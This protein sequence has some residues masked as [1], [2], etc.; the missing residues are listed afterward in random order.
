MIPVWIINLADS[1]VDRSYLKQLYE[2][3]PAHKK[4]YWFVTDIEAEAVTDERSC[5][6]L[7]NELI[8]KGRNCYDFF[9]DKGFT[10]NNLQVCIIGTATEQVTRTTFHLIPSMLREFMSSIQSEYVHRGIEITGLLYVPHNMNHAPERERAECALFIEEMNT[11]V[12]KLDVDTYSRIVV[13]QNIQRPDNGARFYSELNE[14]QQTAYIFQLLLHIYYQDEKQTKIFDSRGLD[15][16]GYYSLGAASIYYDSREHKEQKALALLARLTEM[17]KDPSYVFEDDTENMVTSRFPKAS[18][19]AE[20][21]LERLKENCQGLNVDLKTLEAQPNPHPIN[22]FYKA[23]LYVSYYMDYLKFMPA[24]ALEF[25]RLYSYML[26]KKLFGQIKENKLRLKE[27]FDTILKQYN[28]I[29]AEEDYKYPTFPQLKAALEELKKRFGKEKEQVERVLVREEQAVFEIPE[30]LSVYFN[31]FKS[32]DTE[33]SLKD[34]AEKMKEKLKWEP[35]VMSTLNRSFLLGTVMVFVLLPLLSHLSPF[36]INL[37]DVDKYSYLWIGVIFLLPFAYQLF[38]RLHRHFLSICNSKRMMLAKSLVEVRQKTSAMLCREAADFYAMMIKACDDE[39]KKYQAIEDNL[40]V[41]R[42]RE[43]NAE[44]PHTFF[45]QPL[46]DGSFGGKKMLLKDDVMGD[47]IVLNGMTMSLSKFRDNDYFN[48][49]NGIFKNPDTYLFSVTGEDEAAIEQKITLTLEK[50]R[51]LLYEKL[52]IDDEQCL[53]K[54]INE[55][56]QKDDKAVELIPLFRMAGVNGVITDSASERGYVIRSYNKLLHLPKEASDAIYFENDKDA[57]PF[58]FVTTWSRPYPNKLSAKAICDTQASLSKE[59]LPF[60][61]MLTCL[62]AQYKK[63]D[64]NYCVAGIKTP[65]T[66]DELRQLESN[67]N[68][69]KP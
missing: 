36:I 10:I 17:V 57:K 8:S 25:V 56:Q 24:R 14:E 47:D 49:L 32:E 53:T 62:Y 33:T 21:T 11:I 39:I 7:L 30:Y 51:S 31:K 29:F 4:P 48:L 46:I 23:G 45:N 18:I 43:S 38:V 13:C 26:T 35:T 66:T 61:T 19:A 40:S 58:V 42:Q 27:H 34:I 68:K 20:T 59:P 55:I 1:D 22:D 64:N 3:M 15:R 52:K 12:E 69:M 50:I 28:M 44:L 9:Q 6:V 37:G 16:T 2:G 65:I 63:K 5:A 54:V 60:S 41:K 67:I